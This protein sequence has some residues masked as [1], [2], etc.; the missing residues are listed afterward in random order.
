MTAVAAAHTVGAAC[1]SLFSLPEVTMGKINW[2][3]VVL[4]GLL[5]GV[6]LNIVDFLTYGVWLKA[7]MAA[8]M[9]ALGKQPGA[10]D[11]AIPLRVTLDFVS[12]IG[13]V[14]VYAAIRP[15]FGAGVKTA[16][17]AGLAVWFFVGL[18]HA[19][20]EAPMGFMP[21][22]LMTIGTCVALVALPVATVVGA[23]VYKEM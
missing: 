20:G 1:W 23:Y 14:W 5:A 2:G 8:A 12:G 4:G 7:D 10:M 21:Q 19:I 22:S 13:L 16:V 17:I 11:A 18:V 9:T 15:R 6:V 3:R